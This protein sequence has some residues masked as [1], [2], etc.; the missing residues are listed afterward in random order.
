MLFI[1]SLAQDKRHTGCGEVH[2]IEGRNRVFMIRRGYCI[3]SG[4]NHEKGFSFQENGECRCSDRF[5]FE[6][7][8]EQLTHIKWFGNQIPC[9]NTSFLHGIPGW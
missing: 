6:D 4:A 2:S 1:L 3:L 5:R 7:L 8:C 9:K